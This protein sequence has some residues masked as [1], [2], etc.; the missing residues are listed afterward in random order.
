MSCSGTKTAPSF[1]ILKN[2]VWNHLCF[3]WSSATGD[4]QF[5]VNGTERVTGILKKDHTIPSNGLLVI[6]A[7]KA[8]AGIVN[9]FVGTMSC[10]QMWHNRLSITKITALFEANKCET[11]FEPFFNWNGVKGETP[12]G[13]VTWKTPSSVTKTNQGT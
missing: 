7:K 4:Y 10:L 8:T 13:N 12:V 11:L 2:D 5:H 9:P 3:A 6:G 1:R